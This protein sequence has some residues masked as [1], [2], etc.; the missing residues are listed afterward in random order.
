M[1]KGSCWSKTGVCHIPLN[2]QQ[3]LIKFTPLVYCM[4]TLQ[5]VKFDIICIMVA[6]L[7]DKSLLTVIEFSIKLIPINL[8][9][10]Q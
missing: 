10:S 6:M 7:A 9:A 1:N 3:I 5:I 8:L 2:I 4:K